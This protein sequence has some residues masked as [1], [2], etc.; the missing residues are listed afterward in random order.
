MMN[1]AEKYKEEGRRHGMCDQVFNELNPDTTKDE[2]VEKWVANIDFAIQSGWPTVEQIK[3]DFGDVIHKYNVYADENVNLFDVPNV[4]LNG[5]CDASV[6][7]KKH[8]GRV[9]ARHNTNLVVNAT[10]TSRVFVSLYDNANVKVKTTVFARVYVYQ[11]GAGKIESEGNVLI[12][13]KE[14]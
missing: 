7:Y 13:K 14:R 4:V 6:E 12:R 2:L 8:M 11:N 1:L 5:Q 9:Y 3:E 10:G